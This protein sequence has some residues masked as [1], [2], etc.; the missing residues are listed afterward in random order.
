M[1]INGGYIRVPLAISRSCS[2][3]NSYSVLR[4]SMVYVDVFRKMT[5][6]VRDLINALLGNSPVNSPTHTR[7]Q[8]Y[9]RG[10][11][12]VVGVGSSQRANELAG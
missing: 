7:G 9:G 8:E 6:I 5:N 1:A 12:Q 11:F 10:V 3:E 2:P 4:I